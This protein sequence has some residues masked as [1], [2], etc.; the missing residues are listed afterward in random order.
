[1][2]IGLP[3]SSIVAVSIFLTPPPA[4]FGN[5]NIPL[6]LGD[7]PNVIDV[8]ERLRTYTSL[9]QVA[10][11]FGTTAPEYLAA[12]LYFGQSPQP[13]TLYIG[14]WAK[15][16]TP[17]LNRGGALSAAQQQMS[18]WTSI[19]AGQ[20]KVSIDNSAVTNVTCGTFA[21]QT[22]LNGVAS[23]IQTALQAVGSGGFTAATCIWNGSQFIIRSGTTGILSSVSALTAGTANDISAQLLMTAGTLTYLQPGIAPESAVAAVTLFDT[24]INTAWYGLTFA[25]GTNNQDIADSD[26]QAVAAYI[27]GATNPHIYAITTQNTSAIVSPDTTSI[28]A[29]LKTLGY[30]RSFVQ[31]S[32]S[33]PFAVASMLGRMAT[34]NFDGNSTTITLM[35]KQ[36]PGITAEVLTPTQAAALNSNNYNYFAAFNNNTFIIVNGK[37]ASGQFIDTIWGVDWLA[38]NIQGNVYNLLYG[39]NK[40]PQTDAGMHQIATA[41]E[42]SLAQGVNNGLLAPGTWQAAGFGQLVT[43]QFLQKGYYVYQPPLATQSQTDRAARKSVPFQVAAKLAGAVHSV[44]ITLNVN[45]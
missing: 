36:E 17:G 11:D 14:R 24:Q 1:M 25:A 45:P 6:I 29:V 38:N 7:T 31:Y 23:I 18:N 16:A 21:A 28:G 12:Q 43:G 39:S 9:S 10:T 3:V 34:V 22:N 26:H 32:S 20:F 2:T 37:V 44:N 27:E 8:K 5:F 41:I 15:T 35:F 42:A 40:V 4:Q 19:T 30:N 33:N 13:Q